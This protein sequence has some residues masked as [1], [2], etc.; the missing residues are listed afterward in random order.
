MTRDGHLK[1]AKEEGELDCE[2]E[3][4]EQ[5]Q[6]RLRVSDREAVSLLRGQYLRSEMQQWTP[7]REMMTRIYLVRLLIVGND[8][9]G[10]NNSSTEVGVN[11]QGDHL[12]ISTISPPCNFL[13]G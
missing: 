7:D 1:P 2:K 6:L 10:A 12:I 13:F 3:R 5:V 4:V 9:L 11:C 8:P